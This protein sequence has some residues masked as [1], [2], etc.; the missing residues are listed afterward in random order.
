MRRHS[1]WAR[2]SPGA[3]CPSH[4]AAF[5]G[6]DAPAKTTSAAVD[7]GAYLLLAPLSVGRHTLHFGG[8]NG[9]E[10]GGSID[11]TYVIQVLPQR[12]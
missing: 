8:T 12:P 11:T 4:P 9:P 6:L 7:A 3:F 1:T 10:L 5:L 2:F